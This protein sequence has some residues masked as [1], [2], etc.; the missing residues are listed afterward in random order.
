MEN[1]T[2]FNRL[3]QTHENE[4]ID[5]GKNVQIHLIFLRHGDK[6]KDGSLTEEGKKEATDF[7]EKLE[8]KD[9]IKGY[10]SPVPRAL[11]TVERV[12]AG[13]PHGKKLTTRIRTELGIR[14]CSKDFFKKFREKENEGFGE[15]AEW[16]LS[17][18]EQ[19][20][21]AETSSP[22]EIAED[23]AFA[24]DRF[25]RMSDRLNSGSNIDLVNGTH[26]SM[27]EALLKEIM[28]R[29]KEG[30]KIV[31]FEKLEEIGGA[32]Q[33]TESMEFL[34]KTD[35]SG[36]KELKLYFRGH[37]YD[38]DMN[39]INKLVGAYRKRTKKTRIMNKLILPFQELT[40][41]DVNCAG[42]KG[43]SLGELAKAGVPVP[44]GFVL[45]SSAF[46][47][48]LKD[49]DLIQEIEAILSGVN[50]KKIHTV[51]NASE[52][53]QFLII[54]RE[55]PENI[56]IEILKFYKKLDNKLV[57]V[58]SS[59]T[60]EDSASAAWAGQLE[61]YLNTT[62][63]T[64]LENVK[65]CWASLFTPR[66]IFY[67]FEKRLRRDKISVAVVVQKMIDA[68]ESGIAFSV[69]PVTQ[70]ENQIIIEAGFGLGEAIVSG[71]ITPDSY[72]IEKQRLKIID[73]NVNEQKRALYKKSKGGSA[74]KNLGEMGKTQ[75]LTEKEIIALS[76]IIIKIENHYGFPCDIEW[77]K[78]KG[79]FYIVQSRPITT[80]RMKRKNRK[81]D[82]KK[83]IIV[84]S[85]ISIFDIDRGSNYFSVVSRKSVL[86]IR[87]C[88]PWGY[89]DNNRYKKIFGFPSPHKPFYDSQRNIFVDKG[90][91]VIERKEALIKIKRDNNYLYKIAN[92]CQEDGDSLW[93]ESLKIKNA[94]FS[95]KTDKELLSI[96]KKGIEDEINLCAY[97]MFPLSLQGFFEESIKKVKPE[98]AIPWVTIELLGFLNYNKKGLDE[99][100][101]Q[102]EHFV[103]LLKAVEEKKITELQAK[104]I[105]RSWK[106]RS[107]SP[108]EEIKKGPVIEDLKEIENI[109][110]KILKENPK[111]MEDYKKG[112]KNSIN[113][114]IGQVMKESQKRADYK[115]A[116]E[117]LEKLLK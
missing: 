3:N 98:L 80:L 27:P 65:K 30:K 68:E 71:S 56:K 117:I 76:K 90:A 89:C 82:L 47:Q 107:Y 44:D 88:F 32:L 25:I 61:S 103:E 12:I 96:F 69:H 18:G 58:R 15:A 87:S 36:E 72:V 23:L 102:I 26:Q 45:L 63:E 70:D 41:N 105:L 5:K 14:P 11:E 112:E 110:K 113:F 93:R 39:I 106:E 108:K 9:A 31:G 8:G 86:L 35:G 101:V 66:A 4:I 37:E 57:A 21:D 50:H 114:L 74:W 97:L 17:Y 116:K 59:A 78:E 94:D 10:S 22:H 20:P 91:I 42:G 40:I 54:S 92:R 28:V 33:P 73:I 100:D 67:R 48:F 51:E 85:N 83:G 99:I 115:K 64:L 29:E 62:E 60:S 34:I 79:N 75:V 81:F 13:A 49:T 55:M 24:L 6:D 53:I 46:D 84:P 109:A 7:G 77:A 19:K 104:D 43:A 95:K 1:Q 2:Q 16:Y 111:A 38:L 52:K